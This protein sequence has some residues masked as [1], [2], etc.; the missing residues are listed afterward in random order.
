MYFKEWVLSHLSNLEPYPL[1]YIFQV[2]FNWGLHVCVHVCN[3][4]QI[5]FVYL[6]ILFIHCL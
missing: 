6:N 1:V 4:I 5:D 2:A 3:N